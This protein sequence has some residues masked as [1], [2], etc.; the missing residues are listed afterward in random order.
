MLNVMFQENLEIDKHLTKTN[1]L[2]IQKITLFNLNKE[3][4]KL[5]ECA[6]ALSDTKLRR[7]DQYF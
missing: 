7:R 2:S 1:V 4:L 5:F 6:H 3:I